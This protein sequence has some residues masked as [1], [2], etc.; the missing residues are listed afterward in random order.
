MCASC[1]DLR[2]DAACQLLGFFLYS[3]EKHDYFKS[4][5][6]FMETSLLGK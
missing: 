3:V 4:G 5:E 6:C 2:E 1:L